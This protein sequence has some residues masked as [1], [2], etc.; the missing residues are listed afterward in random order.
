MLNN[1]KKL[2]FFIICAC[3]T[4]TNYAQADTTKIVNK[5]VVNLYDTTLVIKIPADTTAIIAR[6]KKEYDKNVEEMLFYINEAIT[7]FLKKKK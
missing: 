6:H 4:C 1:I 7:E 2:F 5:R 3:L